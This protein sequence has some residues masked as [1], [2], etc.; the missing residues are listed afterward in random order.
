MFYYP[1]RKQAIKIQ[2]TLETLYLGMQGYYHYG[3]DAWGYVYD[4][5]GVDLKALL[6]TIAVERVNQ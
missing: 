3:E 1:N 2:Q 4:Q 6:E 5:T